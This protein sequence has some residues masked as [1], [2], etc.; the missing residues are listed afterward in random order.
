MIFSRSK[1]KKFTKKIQNY[2]TK[3]KKVGV[4][5]GI[6]IPAN[7]PATNLVKIFANTSYS[8]IEYLHGMQGGKGSNPLGS[9]YF[10]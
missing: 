4:V 6:V 2:S 10:F 8:L 7:R 1:L 9:T 5:L 3:S